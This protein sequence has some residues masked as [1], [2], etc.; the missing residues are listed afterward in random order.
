MNKINSFGSIIV[1]EKNSIILFGVV[2]ILSIRLIFIGIMGLMPQDAYYQ[3]YGEHLALS[4]YDHPPVIAYILRFFTSIFGKKVYVL[5]LADSLIT[6]ITIFSFY[7][8]AL[9]FLSR[10]S[11]KKALILFFSSLLVTILSLI[12]TPDVPLLLFWSLSLISLYH[13][14]FEEKKYYWIWS[15]MMMGL[16]FDSKYTGLFLPLGLVLFIILSNQ[17]RKLIFSGWL[18]LCFLVFLITVSPVIIWNVQNNFASFKFQSADRIDS[19]GSMHFSLIKFL[20]FIGHQSAILSPVLFFF[21]LFF[22]YKSF[23]K[24]LVKRLPISSMQLF[25]FCFF[26]PLFTGFVGISFVYWIKINWVMP[27]YVSGIILISTFFN[28]K[29][30]RFQIIFSLVVHLALAIEV[31]FY[32]VLIKSDDTWM[33]WDNLAEGVKRLKIKH[34]AA[35]VFSADDYKTSAVLDF[36][37]DSMIYGRNVI[38]EQALQFDFIGTDLAALQGKDALFIN[39]IPNFKSD[40]KENLFPPSLPLYFNDITE[41]DPILIE[42]G[43]RIVR[44]FLVFYCKNYHLKK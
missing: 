1:P 30:I 34:H 12:S 7:K 20:G 21:F 23:K 24:Y 44:K 2:L 38:G 11:A 14:V 42:K 33:G 32:P 22:I 13:A 16:A 39:S 26:I 4:Y 10:H 9:L 15:G 27:A 6:F 8:L 29:W 41:L 3:F 43:E 37:L 40:Q 19:A 18:W 31:L 5:K 28:Q 17:Y 36:Y 35:F 25:L